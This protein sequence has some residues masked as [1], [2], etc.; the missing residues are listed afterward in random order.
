MSGDRP[1]VNLADKFRRFDDHWSPK[2]IAQVNGLHI[3]AVKVEGEFVWHKHEDTDELFFVH[4]GQLTIR[5]RDGDVIVGSGELHVVPRGVEHITI[6]EME[7][8][9]L[10]VEPAGT[11][12]TG[13]AAENEKTAH[14]EP[15]I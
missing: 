5:Y 3:K 1:V 2:I 4:R 10:L 13:D 9:I 11:L 7:C 8:E 14:Q 6:A 15:W 12:N